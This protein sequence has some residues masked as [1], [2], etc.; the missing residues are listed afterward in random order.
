MDLFTFHTA[1]KIPFLCQFSS[2]Y[3]YFLLSSFQCKEHGKQFKNTNTNGWDSYVLTTCQA[4]KTWSISSIPFQCECEY[5]SKSS[6][7]PYSK[8]SHIQGHTVSAPHRLE[9]HSKPPSWRFNTTTP[10]RLPITRHY[11][12][13]AMPD[14]PSTGLSQTLHGGTTPSPVSR[15]MCSP[16]SLTC[17]GQPVSTVRIHGHLL[18]FS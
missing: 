1:I 17:P 9:L 2:I 5:V 18:F 11:S 8:M 6:P 7:F 12:M 15:T 3:W 16:R 13:C 14:P 10:P 4:N